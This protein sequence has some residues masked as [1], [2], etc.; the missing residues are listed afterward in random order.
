M[1]TSEQSLW[2]KCK[3]ELVVGIEDRKNMIYYEGQYETK[4]SRARWKCV[5]VYFQG[6]IQEEGHKLEMDPEYFAF[7]PS[8]SR[9]GTIVLL[10][11]RFSISFPDIASTIVHQDGTEDKNVENN[12][13]A[14]DTDTDLGILLVKPAR[15]DN[16][17]ALYDNLVSRPATSARHLSALLRNFGVSETSRLILVG[18]S[19]G[20]LVLLTLFAEYGNLRIALDEQ[21]DNSVVPMLDWEEPSF[22]ALPSYEPQQRIG[23][24]NTPRSHL[25]RYSKDILLL[26]DRISYIHILDGHRFPTQAQITQKVA[27]WLFDRAFTAFP[28]FILVHATPRQICD[29]RRTFIMIEHQHFLQTFEQFFQALVSNRSSTNLPSAFFSSLFSH[30]E[31]FQNEKASSSLHSHFDIHLVFS[32]SPLNATPLL[33]HS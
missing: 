18:F 23:R 26:F 28:A 4:E 25:T 29:R 22:V 12:A 8:Y 30:F 11:N 24:T 19:K 33:L 9:E 15:M 32:L 20:G 7:A 3:K 13:H 27:Q 16:H 31:Y 17:E 21:D 6:D 5:V 2:Y 10:R 1:A 14:F